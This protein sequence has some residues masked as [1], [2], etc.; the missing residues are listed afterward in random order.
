MSQTVNETNLGAWAAQQI[1]PDCGNTGFRID[2]AFQAQ[3]KGT[4]SLAGVQDK[5]A[6]TSV[7][8]AKC[9]LTATDGCGLAKT[10]T[11]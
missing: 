5:V 11:R 1:C 10:G 4:Y 2:W 8:V 9:G 3:P 7:P 6:A